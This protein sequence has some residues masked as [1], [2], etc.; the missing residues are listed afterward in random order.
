VTLTP[1]I[2]HTIEQVLSRLQAQGVLLS[3][4]ELE[5]A[6]RA[7]RERYG[8]QVL[9][10]LSG[11]PL[12]VGMFD[13]G[14][15]SSLL[16]W[17]DHGDTEDPRLDKG[18]FGLIGGGGQYQR[19][20]LFRRA[21]STTWVAGPSKKNHRTLTIDQ[22]I[23][24]AA[25]Y[26]DQLIAGAHVLDAMPSMASES[27]YVRLQEQLERVAPALCHR[28]W[29]H[30]YYHMLRPDLLDDYHIPKLQR[31][32]LERLGL[33]I[34]VR[35]GRYVC[36]HRYAQVARELGMPMNH[37]AAALNHWRAEQS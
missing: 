9:A 7:F 27:E 1:S 26:R 17:L 5:T 21:G 24:L 32:H 28:A 11:E 37:L 6:Y 18:R 35:E 25:T 22:A 3:A 33:E 14:N 23:E 34:P 2:R 4:R 12:L 15:R 16:H 19:F 30:K 36:G 31:A 29:V 8:P 13:G 10:G 20:G